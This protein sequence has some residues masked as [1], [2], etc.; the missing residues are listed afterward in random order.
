MEIDESMPM[1][2]PFASIASASRSLRNAMDSLAQAAARIP[3]FV[4]AI[5]VAV[6]CIAIAV[7]VLR[8]SLVDLH[9]PLASAGDAAAAQYM[10]K[11]TLDHG[12]YTRNP[13]VGAPFGANMYDFA[14]PE[15]THFIV[16]RLL[17]L[18]GDDPFFVY[19][20]FYLFSFVSAALAGWWALRFIS[21]ERPLA[22]AGAFLFSMLPYHFFRQGHLFLAA[23]FSASIFAAHAI[24]LALYRAPHVRDELRVT[25][26]SLLLLAIAAGGGIYYAFFGCMFIAAGAVLGAIHSRRTEPLRIGAIYVVLIVGIVALSLLPNALCYLAEGTNPAVAKRLPQEAEIYGLRITQLLLPSNGHRFDWL[27][28]FTTAYDAQTPLINENKTASLGLLAGCGLVAAMA[29]SLVGARKRFPRVAAV[30]TLAIVG[31]LFATIGGFGSLFALLVTPELRALNRISVFIGFFAIL[32]AL[33]LARRAF[34]TR[35]AAI[36]LIGIGF[37][38]VGGFDQI[39]TRGITRVDPTFKQQQPFYDRI[40]ATLPTGT[41]VFE[42]P[43][44][45]FPE[46]PKTGVLMSYDLFEP[47]LRTRGLRWSFGGIHDRPSDIWNEHAATLEGAD[48]VGAL[49]GA[50]FGAIYLNRRGYADHGAAV[51]RSL[52]AVLGAPVL[53]DLDKVEVVYV[54]PP[55]L[56]AIPRPPFV[57]V[58]PGR[59]WR[60]WGKNSKG[61]PEGWTERTST[62]LVVANP[63]A[64]VPFVAEFSLMSMQARHLAI[65]YGGAHIGDYELQAGTKQ[66]I[67]LK[68]TPQPGISR[69]RLDTDVH[70][71]TDATADARQLAMRIDD[72]AY[73]PVPAP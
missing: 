2:R 69:L 19:N 57:V 18:V 49:A 7:N 4:D 47:Y 64:A 21:M 28:A 8:A 54:I 15:P 23:Y 70:A 16:V 50:G 27:S 40:Q 25:A 30:G 44:M 31:I 11:T 46:N 26:L 51:E 17:G 1:E 66:Q 39:P 71:G 42:L 20:L 73:G 45:Y 3:T 48:L 41:A 67:A 65:E 56:A 43:H 14:I 60:P 6:L 58:G 32:S 38:I 61:E 10:I 63:G 62:D 12:W 13:D 24:R 9:T 5:F 29:I 72:L 52:A 37:M 22:I 59:G 34:G 53:E 68:F 35:P 55:A 36:A 33:L